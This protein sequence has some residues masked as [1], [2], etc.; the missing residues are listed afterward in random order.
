MKHLLF[1]FFI[2]LSLTGFSQTEKQWGKRVNIKEVINNA[3]E[4]SL[5]GNGSHDDADALAQGLHLTAGT[6]V[7]YLPAGIYLLK[8]QIN[9]YTSNLHIQGAGIGK[10]II[11]W[12]S[13][14][15]GNKALF[16]SN[17]A[18]NLSFEGISFSGNQK[19]LKAVLEF[20]SYPNQNKNISISNCEFVNVW[21]KQAINFGG[22]AAGEK[23]S[24]DNVVIDSC[25]FYN[26]FNPSY[27]IVTNETDPKCDGINLQQTT[28]RAEIKNCHFENL[29]GD[30]IFGWGS[31]ESQTSKD[32]NLYY[33]NWNIHR[34]YFNLCWMG[35]EVNGGGLGSHLNIHH[36]TL[37]CSTHNGGFLI[38]VDGYY[39][40]VEN[41]TL[42]NVDRSLIEY[43]GIEGDIENNTGIITT[44]SSKSGGVPPSNT[45][46][47]INCLELYG[48]NNLIDNNH[49]TL[50]RSQP[51]EHS[52][53]E[54]NGIALIG[55]TTDPKT[56]PLSYKGIDDYPAFWTITNNTISGFTHKL[57]YA[58][59]NK[60]R[61]VVIKNNVFGSASVSTSPIEI[62]GYNWEITNNTFDLTGS[63]P[64]ETSHV[65]RAFYLQQDKTTSNV[66]SNKIINANWDNEHHRYGDKI[67]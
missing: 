4:S 29:S 13:T 47:R 3:Q 10:T 22:A 23:H 61:N 58:N 8:K 5:V 48:Y 44:Y 40:K 37:R 64:A 62:F 43:T 67:Q 56:Q 27:K 41:N 50:D 66:S 38:S 55:K 49:F 30:G 32:S 24:N 35:I 65:V 20:N 26:L 57:I 36:N 51:D 59:N 34:N 31:L 15:A 18:S 63:T 2:A 28:L 19:E 16:Q 17:G 6:S 14:Y 53:Q 60:I 45:E 39:A 12:D 9:L 7:L 25:R 11:Q 42:Y 1:T 54:F 46:A 21:A 33:G 52:P